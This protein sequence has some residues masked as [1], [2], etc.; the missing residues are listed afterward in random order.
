MPPGP[1]AKDQHGQ[2]E[3]FLRALPFSFGIWRGFAAMPRLHC[4]AKP[5]NWAQSLA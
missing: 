5:P 3:G 4:S 1:V 2:G